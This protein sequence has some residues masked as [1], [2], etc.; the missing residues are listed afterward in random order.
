VAQAPEVG[1]SREYLEYSKKEARLNTLKSR[2]DEA[3]ESFARTLERKAHTKV[4]KRQ[5]EFADRLAEIAK[6]R[7][8]WVTEYTSLRQELKYR[9]P[10]KGQDID[11]RFVPAKEKTAEELEQSAEIDVLLTTIKR[12]V[13]KKYAPFMPKEEETAQPLIPP[14]KAEESTKKKLRLVK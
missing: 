2:I 7:N 11:K 4:P 9:Y 1:V 6:E 8:Q 10:N 14:T 3:N 12:R 5:H 13:D